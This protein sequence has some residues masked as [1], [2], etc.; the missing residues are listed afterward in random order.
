[1]D[2]EVEGQHYGQ[3]VGPRGGEGR[4]NTRRQLFLLVE[5]RHGNT[6]AKEAGAAVTLAADL[7]DQFQRLFG[8]AP[9]K[10]VARLTHR[11]GLHPAFGLMVGSA[12]FA[13]GLAVSPSAASPRMVRRPRD[14]LRGPLTA[15]DSEGM[16]APISSYVYSV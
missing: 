12:D 10:Q 7:P 9:K 4:V 8:R 13:L 15:G 6:E 3:I 11:P 1:M 14:Q 2:V 5:G 16:I